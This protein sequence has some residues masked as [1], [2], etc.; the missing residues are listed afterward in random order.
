MQVPIVRDMSVLEFV[1]RRRRVVITD[2]GV[3][4]HLVHA[5][6]AGVQSGLAALENLS[7][8]GPLV[9]AQGHRQQGPAR[10]PPVGLRPRG[11]QAL[12]RGGNGA[13]T[14]CSSGTA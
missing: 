4:I 14:V 5:R 13:S 9:E 3:P 8:A 6:R 2:V 7:M 12:Q 1:L 11:L 10:R